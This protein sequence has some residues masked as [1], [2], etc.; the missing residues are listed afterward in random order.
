MC[1]VVGLVHATLVTDKRCLEWVL[2]QKGLCS[3]LCTTTRTCQVLPAL[4]FKVSQPLC[5]AF[6]QVMS[7]LQSARSMVAAWPYCP[8]PLAITNVLQEQQDSITAAAAE[9][10]VRPS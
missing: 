4:P 1:T 2:G 5:C 9:L 3:V 6:L 7:P 8:D 10:P